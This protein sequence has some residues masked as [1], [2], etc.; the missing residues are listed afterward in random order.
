MKIVL[1]SA[2]LTVLGGSETYLLTLGRHLQ[3]LGHDVTFVEQNG[4]AGSLVNDAGLVQIATPTDV[5]RP[6][7]VLVQDAIVAAELAVAWPDVPQ[8]FVAHSVIHD[9]QL[10]D[11]LPPNVRAVVALNDRTA[12][13]AGAL[14]AEIPVVRLRQPIDVGHF[15]PGPPPRDVPRTMLLFGNNSSEWRYSG[16]RR[17]CERR[18]I[19]VVRVGGDTRVT[20]P[21]QFLR[22]ADIVVGYGRCVLEAMACGR[23]AL[24]F[25]RFGSD[26]WVTAETYPTL[27]ASGFNGTAGLDIAG[28]DD[29]AEILDAYAPATGAVLHDI[30]YRHHD[31]RDH[32]IAILDEL[33]ALGP[34]TPADPSLAFALARTWRQ[35]WYWETQ[36]IDARLA[37]CTVRER[38]ATIAQLRSQLAETE[39][40]VRDLESVDEVAQRLGHE[41]ESVLA[42]RRYQIGAAIADLALAP[43]RALRRRR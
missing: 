40:Q 16:L 12:A 18:Q 11:S 23:T 9:L 4:S 19:E 27:E 43:R 7:R 38:D 15:T 34:V 35:Q 32:A 21:S 22:G 41:L 26:G 5:G 30:A 31:A 28:R 6:D 3:R 2:S 39:Q 1:A 10:T 36:A 20:D 13:R 8:L 42:S 24:V 33:T 25:D 17:E 29:F 14:A 37:E